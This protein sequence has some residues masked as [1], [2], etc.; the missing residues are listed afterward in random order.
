ML[1]KG[2][3]GLAGRVGWVSRMEVMFNGQTDLTD[4]RRECRWKT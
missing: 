3:G 4:T 1:E 2:I